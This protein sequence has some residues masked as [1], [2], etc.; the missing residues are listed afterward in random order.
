MINLTVNKVDLESLTVAGAQELMDA[1]TLT[2]VELTQAYLDRIAALN[3][4]G[5]GL[6]AVRIL[7]PDALPEAAAA[8]TQR[9]QG[10]DLGPLHGIPVLVKDNIDAAGLPTTAGAVALEQSFAA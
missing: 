6:N 5:P 1:G 3:S 2:S 8:D 7:N 10:H 4:R 9:A